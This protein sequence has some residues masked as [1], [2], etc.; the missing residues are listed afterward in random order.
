[1]VA[2]ASN[3]A[4]AFFCQS[5]FTRIRELFK[6][7]RI[8]CFHKSLDLTEEVYTQGSLGNRAARGPGTC[9]G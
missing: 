7:N 2:I 9:R 1:M 6:V 5:H 4:V 8:K 3:D